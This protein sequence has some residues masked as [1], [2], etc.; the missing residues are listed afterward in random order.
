M[1]KIYLSALMACLI[2]TITPIKAF[3]PSIALGSLIIY[4]FVSLFRTWTRDPKPHK[5][6]KPFLN[7]S[8][9]LFKTNRKQW[10]KNMWENI[11]IFQ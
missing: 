9:K 4:E 10:R 1:K 2:T 7:I 11:K 6:P 3:D 8:S 5:K